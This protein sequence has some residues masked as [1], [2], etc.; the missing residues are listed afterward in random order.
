M[1]VLGLAFVVALSGAIAP[2]PLLALVIS[3]VLAQGFRAALFLLVG[4]ALIE[5]VFVVGLRHGLGRLLAR[6]RV[7]ATLGGIGAGVLGWMGVT[8]WLAAPGA[9]LVAGPQAAMAWYGLIVAGIGVSLSNPYFTGWWATVGTG[10]MAAL[11]LR[12]NRDY[13]A[14]FVG[15][16]L[17]DAAWYLLVAALLAGG[18]QWLTGGLYQGLLRGCAAAILA[19]AVVFLVLSLR[20]LRR[21]ASSPAA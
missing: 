18:R 9:T 20:V 14:F 19:L 5:I 17:G 12:T 4:H 3:Q 11:D 21:P 15:H 1:R 2:G 7:R 16:E 6:P 10:Q 13:L 8:L